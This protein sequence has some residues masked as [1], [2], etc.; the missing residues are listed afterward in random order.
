MAARRE[1]LDPRPSNPRPSNP[2]PSNPRPPDPR[3]P[4]PRHRAGRLGEALAASYLAL[5]GYEI[6]AQNVRAGRYEI[7]IVARRG[8]LVCLIEVRLRR[9]GRFMSAIETIDG[10]KCRHLRRAAPEVLASHP[11]AACRVDVIAIDWAPEGGLTLTHVPGALA[12]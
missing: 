12:G 2:R 4:D 1:P 11:G 5:S 3:P 7:D 8:D 10:Q 6:V 9:R